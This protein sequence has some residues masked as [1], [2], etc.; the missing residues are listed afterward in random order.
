MIFAITLWSSSQHLH[1][2]IE[3]DIASLH[4]IISSKT[5]ELTDEQ[6]LDVVRGIYACDDISPEKI[7]IKLSHMQTP[8]KVIRYLLVDF[9]DPAYRTKRMTGKPLSVT[10]EDL[11]SF[12][13]PRY[14]ARTPNYFPDTIIHTCDNEEQTEHVMKLFEELDNGT[15]E[16]EPES[17]V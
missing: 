1:D 8:K 5:Y 12:I 13:R 9:A 2:E 16:A 15:E 17:T 11:K 10:G 4:T 6:H 3:K 14:R 7:E